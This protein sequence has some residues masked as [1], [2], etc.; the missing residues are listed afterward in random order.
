MLSNEMLLLINTGSFSISINSKVGISDPEQGLKQCTNAGAQVTQD[1]FLQVSSSE[2]WNWPGTSDQ[3]GHS[4][5]QHANCE[6]GI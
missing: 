1:S 2:A 3:Q 5:M 6:S 4:P